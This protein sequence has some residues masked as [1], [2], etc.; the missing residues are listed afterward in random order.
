[1]DRRHTGRSGWGGRLHVS[2][3]CGVRR[4]MRRGRARTVRPL[5]WRNARGV[6]A[7]GAGLAVAAGVVLTGCS[8]EPPITAPATTTTSRTVVPTST[9]TTTTSSP[10]SSTST[11]PTSSVSIPPAA[12]AKTPAGAEEFVRYY[13]AAL[14]RGAS[15]PSSAEVRTLSDPGCVVCGILIRN[16]EKYVAAGKGFDKPAWIAEGV[17]LN[18]DSGDTWTVIANIHQPAQVLRDSAG[19]VID[20]M[21]DSRFRML[22]TIRYTTS[23]KV[24]QMQKVKP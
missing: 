19:K 22:F 16:I 10:P 24:L 3:R 8:T 6:T 9:T 15:Q 18:T 13:I 4:S 1:M 14:D 20:T 5:R 12:Q 23:W 21:S 17:G 7:V 2:G 11:A